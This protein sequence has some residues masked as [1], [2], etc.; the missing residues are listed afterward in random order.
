[1]LGHFVPGRN[2]VER[3]R[4]G[5]LFIQICQS[6]SQILYELAVCLWELLDQEAYIFIS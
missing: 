2:N 4:D 3:F 1:M 6:Y 5:M